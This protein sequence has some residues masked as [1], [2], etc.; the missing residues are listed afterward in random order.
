MVVNQRHRGG[1]WLSLGDYNFDPATAPPMV[2]FN[3]PGAQ[4]LVIADAVEFV[5]LTYDPQLFRH[6]TGFRAL[7]SQFNNDL[8]IV[9]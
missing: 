1:E 8:Q 9:G 5:Q 3:V 4:R 6:R 2:T 7:P